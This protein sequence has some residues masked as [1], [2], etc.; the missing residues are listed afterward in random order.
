MT[1][2]VGSPAEEIKKSSPQNDTTEQRDASFR[3]TQTDGIIARVNNEVITRSELEKKSQQVALEKETIL[4][5]LIEEHLLMQAALEENI[6]VTDEQ[7]EQVLEKQI[8]QIGSRESFMQDVLVPLN[9]SWSEYRAELKRQLTREKFITDKM[10]LRP[11]EQTEPN[12]SNFL[13]DTFISPKEIKEY[14]ETHKDKFN[15]NQIK[16]CQIILRFKDE[17]EKFITK[18]GFNHHG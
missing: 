4:K 14:Y 11:L 1:I 15:R 6:E 10:R 12:K 13:I 8:V 16:T 18:Y 5:A 9:I 2:S 17:Y 3:A 7:V